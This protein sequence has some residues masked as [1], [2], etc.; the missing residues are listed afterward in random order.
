VPKETTPKKS[1]TFKIKSITAKGE[2]TLEFSKLMNFPSNMKE[3]INEQRRK[4]EAEDDDMPS[5]IEQILVL[6]V[7]PGLDQNQENTQFLWEVTSI[8]NTS[9]IIKVYFEKPL[10][11]SQST[12]RD[13]LQVTIGKLQYFTDTDSLQPSK[14]TATL[15]RNIKRQV[16]DSAVTNFT[17]KAG[18]S[19]S[20][21]S[22]TVFVSNVLLNWW[23]SG[24]LN[25]LWGLVNSLQM[26]VH[27]SL[28]SVS[29]P[30]NALFFF[31][32]FV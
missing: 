7:L 11:I 14:K 12:T 28:T 26:V 24:S 30:A 27:L 6:K 17:E 8:N 3:L 22:K 21:S 19:V 23:L 32:Y 31:S 5:E 9:I 16:K 1:P 20:G 10:M 25:L 2:T 4:I 29:F 13:A 18:L 15:V